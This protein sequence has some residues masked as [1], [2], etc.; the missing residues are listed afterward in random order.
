MSAT[1]LPDRK[2][3]SGALA[4]GSILGLTLGALDMVR[5]FSS[6]PPGLASFPAVLD[7][8]AVTV[9]A[10][11]LT[12]LFSW[13]LLV[14]ILRHFF[15]TELLPVSIALAVFI[16]S[17]FAGS[18]L[19]EIPLL[20][21][22][23]PDRIVYVMIA[24]GLV[25]GSYFTAIT[26]AKAPA[27]VA[28]AARIIFTLPL[29]LFLTMLCAWA[30]TYR[31]EWFPGFRPTASVAALILS[32]CVIFFL[33]SRISNSWSLG[34]IVIAFTL[35]VVL[36][37]LFVRLPGL[38][39]RSVL[40][41]RGGGR[42]HAIPRVL[43]ITVD[44][45]RADALSVFGETDVLTPQIDR[46][47]RDGILFTRV[48]SSAPWTLPSIASIMTGLS[49]EV[50]RV[51]RPESRLPDAVTTLS[52]R[53]RDFG[54]LTAAIG[55]NVFL[56]PDHNLA[57]GFDAYGFFPRPSMGYSFGIEVLRKLFPERYRRNITT[58]E[59]TKL[60]VDWL[61]SLQDD[62]FFL[63]IHYLDPHIPYEPPDPF[64][65]ERASS[66]SIGNRFS[67]I[68][69]IR[70]GRLSPSPEEQE[71][72]RDLYH[73][74]VRY[75]DD[76]IGIL[77]DSLKS[78]GLYEGTLIIFT[79]DHG[80]EFWEHGGFEHGHALFDEILRVPLVI[81]LPF[82]AMTGRISRPV[83]TQRIMPTILDL[84]RIEG[85]DEDLLDESLSSL[86]AEKAPGVG[87]PP[88]FSTG[89]LY[90][91]DRESVVFDELKFIRRLGSGEGELYDLIRDPFE[92]T[93][94]G[95]ISPT[96]VREAIRLLDGHHRKSR[97]I[98]EQLRI[99][100]EERIKLD[101]ETVQWLKTLGYI[102]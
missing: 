100:E 58:R 101:R 55:S 15:N 43:L 10:I 75:V 84:C 92:T 62:D 3:I 44:T 39:S 30:Q 8:V 79:S 28:W 66:T 12:Y 18:Y 85:E 2:T 97:V 40:D 41:R 51:T 25:S 35:L 56:T 74:E 26:S 94:I 76:N 88:L 78:L 59:L 69:A 63:W 71:R 14:S 37:P 7:P 64:L 90:G 77:I 20:R 5:S 102:Q 73:G 80:E 60:A 45:L 1:I 47:A 54:Y 19:L 89:L 11:L 96:A 27:I 48:L 83:S 33:C 17:L 68:D 4:I 9:G 38:L 82:P 50:H 72:I 29:W 91:E 65:P 52:E 61:E 95:D 46:L 81:K 93:S 31:P 57:Q 36:S 6:H 24:I 22:P 53:L 49:P 42:D 70:S 23:F 86:W 13:I 34:R 21:V 99:V 98:G 32:F 16:G 67:A 87:N